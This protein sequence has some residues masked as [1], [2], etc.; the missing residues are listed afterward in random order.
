MTSQELIDLT[1]EQQRAFNRMIKAAA[2]FKKAGG[3]FYAVLHKIHGLNGEFIDSILVDVDRG[4]HFD[5]QFDVFISD[6][7]NHHDLSGF[8]DDN[9]MVRLNDKGLKLWDG[10][11]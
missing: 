9:H 1:P 7:I 6:V 4:G 5:T 10:V 3:L 2:D 11:K 8:A